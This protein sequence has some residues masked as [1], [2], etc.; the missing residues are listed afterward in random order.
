[1]NKML[2]KKLQDWKI[3]TE[4]MTLC[5]KFKK[6]LRLNPEIAQIILDATSFLKYSADFSVR[7][8]CI[9]KGI[10]EQP[11]C[12]TC[13]KVLKMRVDGIY[14]YTFP[15][16]CSSKC[17][18]VVEDVKEKRLRT[19]MEKYGASSFRVTEEGKQQARQTHLKNMENGR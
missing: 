12:K 8:H 2:I 13:G 16:Y 11:I 15:N 4:D 19:N 17:F 14:R 6:K 3:I 9:I 7:L 5:V 1:M 18:S 10:I